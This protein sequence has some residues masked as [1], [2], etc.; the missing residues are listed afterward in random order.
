ML[1]MDATLLQGWSLVR[2]VPR[3]WGCAWPGELGCIVWLVLS[4]SYLVRCYQQHALP[5]LVLSHA[6]MV[7]FWVVC[8]MLLSM[9]HAEGDMV[10]VLCGAV[11]LM[12]Q[13]VSHIHHS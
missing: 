2:T 1:L 9:L 7:W 5:C 13:P 10:G 6:T 8:G 4:A 11:E 12:E 3:L